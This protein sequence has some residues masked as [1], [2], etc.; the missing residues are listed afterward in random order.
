M[1]CNCDYLDKW[2]LSGRRPDVLEYSDYKAFRY[3]ELLVPDG[4][5]LAKSRRAGQHYPME[6]GAPV[7][8]APTGC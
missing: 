5:D 7:S 1:R 8:R 2:T 4:V 6:R 3:V